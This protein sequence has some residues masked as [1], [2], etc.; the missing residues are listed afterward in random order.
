LRTNIRLPIATNNQFSGI[1]HLVLGHSCTFNELIA[2]LSYTP[3][4]CRLSC[5]EVD[6]SATDNG[7]R[8]VITISNLTHISINQYY[9][10]FDKLEIFILQK[11][12]QLQVLRIGVRADLTYL[13]ADRWER[14]ISQYLTHLR[15]F[16]F[17]YTEPIDEDLALI[18]SHE[19]INRFNSSF[20]IERKWLLRIDIDTDDWM[21]Q[22]AIIYSIFSYRYLE[23]S[24]FF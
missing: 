11:S 6:F 24:L 19:L 10:N 1:E 3:R 2:I 18:Q 15:I 8:N 5:T 23:N 7:K 4:L 21:D 13:D 16:E 9:E 22:Y 14:L 20:W 12:S 17:R